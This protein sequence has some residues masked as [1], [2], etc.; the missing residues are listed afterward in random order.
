MVV[1]YQIMNNKNLDQGRYILGVDE[2]GRGPLAGP[3][4]LGFVLMEKGFYG[5]YKRA[6][7]SVPAGRDSKKM[8][9]KERD[10]WFGSVKE[11]KKMG[12][13][14]YFFVMKSAKFIDK[15]GI[16]LSIKKSITEA[17][18]KNKINKNNTLVLLD[19][20]LRAP[21]VYKQKTIIKG[22][23]KEKIISLASVVAKV[24]RD[25]LMIKLSKKYPKYGFEK[26]KGYGTKE[27]KKMIWKYGLSPLHRKTFCHSVLLGNSV[28]K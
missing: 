13:C 6:K 15:H 3:V 11:M 27:H 20:A 12:Q 19:G 22:D 8:S 7:N 5:K 21:F 28:T 24:S 9:T 14:R 16:S 25:R 26:H 17:L 10:R 18:I 1:L 2:A 23:E 4:C